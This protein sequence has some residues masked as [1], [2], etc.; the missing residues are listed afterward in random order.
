MLKSCGSADRSQFLDEKLQG[1][2]DDAG[3]FFA[4]TAAE[5]VVKNHLAAR[6]GHRLQ[7]FQVVGP[8]A[9]TVVHAKERP[10][11]TAVADHAIAGLKAMEERVALPG[12]IEF[13]HPES[14]PARSMG[15]RCSS[16]GP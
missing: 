5:L 2:V 16:L 6:G 11:R 10:M 13:R 7:R 14:T 12:W 3:R 15:V 9:R 4:G 1:P 8:Q